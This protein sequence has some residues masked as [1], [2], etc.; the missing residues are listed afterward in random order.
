[1]RECESIRGVRALF[2]EGSAFTLL[3]FLRLVS[4]LVV[5]RLVMMSTILFSA[6]IIILVVRMRS[7]PLLRSY[8]SLHAWLHASR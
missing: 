2:L 7:L 8:L 4:V 6:F 1:M 5:I 3:F